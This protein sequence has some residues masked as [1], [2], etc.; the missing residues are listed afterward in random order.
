MQQWQYIIPLFLIHH[1]ELEEVLGWVS[2]R[3]SKGIKWSASMEE[4]ECLGFS[5]PFRQRDI[6]FLV[7]FSFRNEAI[8]PESKKTGSQTLP[9][10][11]CNEPT[12]RSEAR[13]KNQPSDGDCVAV[14]VRSLLT[15]SD[16]P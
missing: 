12:A 8:N 3:E 14:A 16:H 9:A 11:V 2:D 13:Q 15:L 4:E 7:I 1:L 5:P 10:P 6:K